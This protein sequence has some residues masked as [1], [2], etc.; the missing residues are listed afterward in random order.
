V[1]DGNW[2]AEVQGDRAIFNSVTNPCPWSGRYTFVVPTSGLVGTPGGDGW[3]TLKVT[4]SGAAG[5]AG[6]LPDNTKLVRT[7]PLSKFGFWPL[8]APAYQ[9]Q[10]SVIGWVRF[11]TNPPLADLSGLLDWFRPPQTDSK[12]YPAGFANH[13][14]FSGSLYVAPAGLTNRVLAMSDG[15]LILTG[16]NLSQSCTND[17]ILGANNHLTNASPNLLSTSLSAG[18]GRFKGSF[19]DTGAVRSV[20]FNGVLLQKSTNGSGFFLGTN[21]SGRV[22]LESNP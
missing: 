2:L 4:A 6:V 17:V 7:A 14:S 10:G 19:F 9:S 1:T 21:Q 3:G 13:T 20:K 11:D 8:Y 12:L 22:L 16:G 15:V 5:G 18:T